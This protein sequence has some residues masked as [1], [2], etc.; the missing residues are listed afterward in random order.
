MSAPRLFGVDLA[1]TAEPTSWTAVTVRGA[2]L[3]LY[4]RETATGWAVSVCDDIE[5]IAWAS[6]ETLEVAESRLRDRLV[7]LRDAT[8]GAVALLGLASEAA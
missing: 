7:R 5:V 4:A 8:A 6:G 1:R 3:T 2:G